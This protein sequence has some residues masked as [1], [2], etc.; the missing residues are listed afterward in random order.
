P[1][2]ARGFKV[3]AGI[4]ARQRL[5]YRGVDRKLVAPRVNAQLEGGWQSVLFH[6]KTN[7]RHVLIELLFE[8]RQVAH[9]VH[10]FVETAREFRG[11]SLKGDALIGERG[12]NH[13]E[14]RR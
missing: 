10:S 14:L 13:Q 3:Q 8:L 1:G 5:A 12:Q 7:Y 2:R 11:D 4:K 6:G 9:I